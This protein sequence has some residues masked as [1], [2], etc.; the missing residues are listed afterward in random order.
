MTLYL[1]GATKWILARNGRHIT[2]G[3]VLENVFI[4]YETFS[5]FFFKLYYFI[6]FLGLLNFANNNC[7]APHIFSESDLQGPLLKIKYIKRSGMNV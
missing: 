2:S 6:L 3:S 7:D 4:L 1:K 5:V